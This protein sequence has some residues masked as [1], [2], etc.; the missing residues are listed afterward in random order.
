MKTLCE[1]FYV[2]AL[3]KKSLCLYA[4]FMKLLEETLIEAAQPSQAPQ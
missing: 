2:Y 1:E 3:Y 4:S